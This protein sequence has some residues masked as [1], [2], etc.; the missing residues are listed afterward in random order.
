[1]TCTEQS[2]NH[3]GHTT[4]ATVD[5]EAQKA[6]VKS[7]CT[8]IH[9]EVYKPFDQTAFYKI[10]TSLASPAATLQG[11]WSSIDS[12][13]QGIVHHLTVTG[14]TQTA[15]NNRLDRDRK[16]RNAAKP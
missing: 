12:A 10:K 1:M 13:I 8:A 2:Y 11:H 14:E 7:T 15:K 16:E 3:K 9:Y 4:V 6:I 5:W